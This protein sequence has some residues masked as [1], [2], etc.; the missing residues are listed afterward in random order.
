[1]KKPITQDELKKFLSYDPDTGHFTWIVDKGPN[2]TR[3]RIAG[4]TN[5]HASGKTYRFI[6]LEYKRYPVHRLIWFYLYGSW[7][8]EIDHINGD[9]TDNRLV[10][11][12]EVTRTENNRNMRLASNN[13]SGLSGV[14]FAKA[15]MK[16]ETY[17]INGNVKRNLGYYSSLFEAACVR[18]SAEKSLGFH[19]NHG[20]NRPL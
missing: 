1:M 10:N 19:A 18:K 17:I 16:W 6:T 9:G 7:P 3:G 8:V 14:S 13:T 20:T 15:R 5:T 11:L 2:A 4:T 12:R